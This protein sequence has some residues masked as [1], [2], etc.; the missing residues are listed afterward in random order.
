MHALRPTTFFEV[1][2]APAQTQ[3]RVGADIY[4]KDAPRAI[5]PWRRLGTRQWIGS[6][7]L[8]ERWRKAA[9]GEHNDAATGE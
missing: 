1:L 2:D 6:Q 5:Y 8:W 4:C 7:L 9:E 3:I